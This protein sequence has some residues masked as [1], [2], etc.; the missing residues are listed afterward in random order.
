VGE[1]DDN[2][3]LDLSALDPARDG[4][5]WERR[6]RETVTR[7]LAARQPRPAALLG[8]LFAWRRP[9]LALAA[10]CAALVWGAS[11]VGG[12]RTPPPAAVTRPAPAR[13]AAGVLS[14]WADGEEQLGTDELLA[15][16]GGAR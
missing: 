2:E 1:H 14:R 3:R 13:D 4:A 8:A 12:Q 7:A 15:V 5:R 16:L 10:A 11:L 9:A 6:I